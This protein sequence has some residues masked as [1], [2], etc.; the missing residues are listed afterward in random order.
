MDRDASRSSLGSAA[1]ELHALRGATVEADAHRVARVATAILLVALLAGSTALFASGARKN[2]QVTDLRD[3]GIAVAVTV[4]SCR[5]LLGG[6]GSNPVG[7]TCVGTYLV[8]TQRYRQTLPT[9]V[10]YASG[11]RITLVAADDDGAL[12]SSRALV[13][14]EHASWRVYLVPSALLL[15]FLVAAGGL[16]WRRRRNAKVPPLPR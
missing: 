16:A 5:G 8:G 15:A 2:N 12:L 4:T 9:S 7:Y 11:T 10:L 13:A 6:S 1:T 14:A 3:H